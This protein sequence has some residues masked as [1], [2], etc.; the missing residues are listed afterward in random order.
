MLPKTMDL[1]CKCSS[2]KTERN[3]KNPLVLLLKTFGWDLIGF[4]WPFSLNRGYNSVCSSDKSSAL[5][6]SF[7]SNFNFFK[8]SGKNNPPVLIKE[9]FL[10]GGNDFAFFFDKDIKVGKTKP[11]G[12]FFSPPLITE[13]IG[14]N[15]MGFEIWNLKLAPKK[16]KKIK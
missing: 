9:G 5:F 13:C 15:L 2:E 11:S 3:K 16:K 14:F 12:S 8:W 1:P 7:N 4:F 6:F 10:I